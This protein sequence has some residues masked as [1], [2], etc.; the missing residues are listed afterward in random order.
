MAITQQK[1][2][3]VIK[4]ECQ[5]VEDRGLGYRSELLAAIADIVKA[6]REHSVRATLIQQQVVDIC[7][8]LGDFSFQ[9]SGNTI[10][11]PPRTN[12]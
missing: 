3:G 7:E 6:E 2:L 9:Q 10:S 4:A 11:R 1:L 8:R 12:K 5:N